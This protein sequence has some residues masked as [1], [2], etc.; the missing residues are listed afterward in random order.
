[1]RDHEQNPV[2]KYISSLVLGLFML[3]NLDFS[4]QNVPMHFPKR[5]QGYRISKHII[6]I[7]AVPMDDERSVPENDLLDRRPVVNHE[8]VLLLLDLLWQVVSGRRVEQHLVFGGIA[9]HSLVL[10][11]DV[12]TDIERGVVPILWVI[13]I[14]RFFL[15]HLLLER[16]SVC[17]L[18]NKIVQFLHSLP[19][20]SNVILPE[21]TVIKSLR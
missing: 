5:F 4:F 6:Q 18:L 19:L 13:Q 15:F 14:C 16:E 8:H 10:R 9:Y 2:H 7:P 17:L 21:S 11:I 1:M 12:E 20:F 3:F